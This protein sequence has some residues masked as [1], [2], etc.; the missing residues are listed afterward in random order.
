MSSPQISEG[1]TGIKIDLQ[2][3]TKEESLEMDPAIH[4][5]LIYDQG[6]FSEQEGKKL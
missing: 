5:Y 4:N 1:F 2:I 3:S 6:S